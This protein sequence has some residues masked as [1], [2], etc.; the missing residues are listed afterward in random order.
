MM[1]FGF[2]LLLMTVSTAH[3][4]SWYDEECCTGYDCKAVDEEDVVVAKDGVHVRWQYHHS[5]PHT[6]ILS[7]TDPRV[8]WSKDEKK[9]VCVSRG[10]LNCVYIPGGGT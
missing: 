3:A 2:L 8:R 5:I 10:G 6:S 1:K 9:H 4:H 7:T